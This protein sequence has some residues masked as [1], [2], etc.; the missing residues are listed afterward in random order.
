VA[1]SQPN[2]GP[3]W[4]FL[5][6][7]LAG[8]SVSGWHALVSANSTARQINQEA[9]LLPV[10]S[11]ALFG[12]TLLAGLAIVYAAAQGVTLGRFDPAQGFR[13]IAGPAGVFASGL[14][15]SL[16]ALGLPASLGDAAS[17]LFLALLVLGAMQLALRFLGQTGDELLGAAL[18]GLRNRA[19]AAAVAAGLI[20]LV[21]LSGFW[22]WL[23]PLFGGANLL[24]ASLALL[25]LGIWLVRQGR[26]SWW[27]LAPALLL[28]ASATAALCYSAGYQALYRAIW[29]GEQTQ[30]G[31]VLGSL[32][33]GG[34]GIVFIISGVTLFSAGWRKILL[35]RASG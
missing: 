35:A 12:E 21:S 8:G 33:T 18:P 28:F 6:V 13:L 26:P 17:T 29:L 34:A 1:T 24:L 25:L 31:A 3:L 16:A 32:I 20:L 7:T 23:W 2:L 27:A 9:H 14:V 22:Q 30:P 15:N 5:F 19:V 11:G 10:T 4:P